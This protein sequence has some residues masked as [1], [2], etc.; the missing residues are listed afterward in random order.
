MTLTT[1]ASQTD[2]LSNLHVLDAVQI[3]SLPWT[4]VT[5]SPGAEQKV[6]WHLHRPH[7]PREAEL[8]SAQR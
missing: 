2:A 1:H 3:E 7:P 6:L 4:A 5:G 8:L